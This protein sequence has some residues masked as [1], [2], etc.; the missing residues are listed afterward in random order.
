MEYRI[1]GD[2]FFN[3]KKST[4]FSEERT[5]FYLAEIVIAI[6]FLH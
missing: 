5:R 1:G 6:E 2:L 3:L 4:F